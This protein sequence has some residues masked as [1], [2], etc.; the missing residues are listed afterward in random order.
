MPKSKS[1]LTSFIAL[2]CSIHKH[3]DSFIRISYAAYRISSLWCIV[4]ISGRKMDFYN[5]LV[6][7]G[8]HV[9]LGVPTAFGFSDGLFSKFFKAPCPSGCTLQEVLSSA[10]TS[11]FIAMILS[12]C[13]A[14][15]IFCITPFFV[16]LSNLLYILFHLPYSFG[17][18]L[19]LHPFSA[20]YKIALINV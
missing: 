5:I 2:I 16:H 20:I 12:R 11:T 13:I 17:S 8:Y 18:A 7:C 9:K 10:N 15:N 14:S 6:I 19:H 1:K 3:R 4:A